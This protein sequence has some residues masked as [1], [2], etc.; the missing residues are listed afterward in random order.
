MCFKLTQMHHSNDYYTVGETANTFYPLSYSS[1]H[2]A[3]Y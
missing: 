1:L 3:D 2:F